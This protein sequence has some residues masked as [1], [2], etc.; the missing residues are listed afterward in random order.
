MRM[1]YSSWGVKCRLIMEP[2]TATTLLVG[3]LHGIPPPQHTDPKYIATQSR[4]MSF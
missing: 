2:D 4:K 3:S 1:G